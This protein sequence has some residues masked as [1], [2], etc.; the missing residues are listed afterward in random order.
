M[1]DEV[2]AG[3]VSLEDDPAPVADPPAP[4]ADPPPVAANPEEAEPEGTVVNPGGEKLV[5]LSALVA[6]RR[7][8]ATAKAEAAALRPKAEKVDQVVREW[9]AAQP[10]LDKVRNGTYQPA[11]QQ[12]PKPEGPLSADEAVEYAKY[13]DLYDTDGKPD[14]GRAQRVAALNAKVSEKQAQQYVAPL[15]Q[16]TA[17][18]QS[19]ANLEQAANFKDQHGHQ[20]DRGILESIWN[21]VPPEMSAQPQIAA[22]LYRQAIAEMVIQGKWKGASAAPPPPPVHTEGVGGGTAPAQTLDSR[23]HAFRTAGD[24]TEKHFT[25]IREKYQPG[26]TN[27]LE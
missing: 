25:S 2:V 18:G 1:S 3:S 4:V 6:Q 5:P 26:R 12:T 20:I 22:V 9:Q 24:M 14:T 10:L 19:R 27:S 11:P 17:Q 13:L 23:D 15:L 21:Q 7:E 8:A 16:H